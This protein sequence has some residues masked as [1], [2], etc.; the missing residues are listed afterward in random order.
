MKRHILMVCMTYACC[1][2]AAVGD[3]AQ[4][5]SALLALSQAMPQQGAP[6]RDVAGEVKSFLD[7]AQKVYDELS[8]LP[9]DSRAR[10][11]KVMDLIDRYAKLDS[12]LRQAVYVEDNT[13]ESDILYG[14]A[15]SFVHIGSDSPNSPEG[16]RA[17]YAV[18]Q[19]L[20]NGEQLKKEDVATMRAFGEISRTEFQE[21]FFKLLNDP[22]ELPTL[23]KFINEYDPLLLTQV[24]QD[25]LQ[26]FAQLVTAMA[27][28][29]QM[30][31]KGPAAD[32]AQFLKAAA[33][34]IAQRQR[35]K[36]RSE[37]DTLFA[38][39]LK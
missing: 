33:Q 22:N 7:A 16:S 21:R 20:R 11:L 38:Q 1:T 13:S 14:L 27:N 28:K 30:A 18:M 15:S 5:Q 23:V 10:V 35:L 6:Q 9:Q 31:G 37:I 39:E 8:P 25:D 19:D 29:M 4:M 12:V 24:S 3:L 32:R 36:K 2:A 17:V 26:K 34:S